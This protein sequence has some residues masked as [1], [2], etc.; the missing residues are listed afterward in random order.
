MAVVTT[1]LHLVEEVLKNPPPAGTLR[2]LARQASVDM[3]LCGPTSKSKLKATLAAMGRSDKL[4]ALSNF[5]DA[6]VISGHDHPVEDKKLSGAKASSLQELFD[7]DEWQAALEHHMGVTRQ[8]ESREDYFGRSFG[9]LLAAKPKELKVLDAYLMAKALNEEEVVNWLITQLATR[10]AERITI[11]TS[12]I[13][14]QRHTGTRQELARRFASKIAKIVTESKFSGQ[15]DL[16]VY[17][18]FL[19]DRYFFFRYSDSGIAFALGSGVDVFRGQIFTELTVAN[20][21]PGHEARSILSSPR[22]KPPSE[23]QFEACSVDDLSE[24]INLWMPQ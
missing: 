21:I 16:Y 8:G 10:G 7:C 12:I 23:Y 1:R 24:Q 18:T 22:L 2:R 13:Q 20:P 5:I 4:E 11:W 3:I 15:V 19:H 9:N 6:L 17:E 14:D